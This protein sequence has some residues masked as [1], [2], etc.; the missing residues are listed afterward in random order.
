MERHIKVQ[1]EL[2][3][4]TLKE[5]YNHIAH[6]IIEHGEETRLKIIWDSEKFRVDLVQ[7]RNDF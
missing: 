5:L 3:G 1:K 7:L 4:M 6:L 2:D